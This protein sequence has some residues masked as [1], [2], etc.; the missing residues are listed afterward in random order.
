MMRLVALLAFIASTIGA[1]AA[2]VQTL[3][4]KDEKLLWR[5]VKLPDGK[6][7]QYTLGVGSAAF[8]HPAD[9]P[10][11]IW[12]LGD[13][14]PNMTCSE[15]GKIL[16]K[17]I[18]DACRKLKNGRIYP[19]PDYTPSIYRLELDRAG[20][21]FRLLETIPLKTKSGR[22][23]TGGLNP[24]TKATKDTGMDLAGNVLPD[25][26]DNVDAE[27]I[28]R[29]SDGTF[30]VAEEMAPSLVHVSGDGRILRRLVPADAAEDYK[31]AEAEIVP[32]LPAILSKRQGNRG[33]EGLAISPDEQFLYFM[34]QNP[35]ANPDVKAFETAKNTRLF[36]LERATGRVVGEYVYQLDDPQTFALDPSDTQSDSRLSEIAALGLDRLLVDERTDGTT[37]LHEITLAGATNIL[38]TKWDDVATSPSLEQQNDLSKLGV[39]PVKKTLRFDTSRDFKNAPVKIEGMAFLGDGTLVLIND[40]DFGIRGDA[41]QILLVKGAV[42]AD[43]AVYKK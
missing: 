2:D 19:T 30:W 43:P 13:R 12:T 31:S 24:Q 40:N 5:S 28:V 16:G 7:V 11:T 37:K 39:V 8:R 22:A 3:N 9:P 1:E 6:T 27:G 21:A 26:P 18:M 20:G 17:E 10:N 42:A 35:L 36:K 38:G 34:L 14:G 29:L 23:I 41:T 25:D 4:S 32:A 33:I 15:S